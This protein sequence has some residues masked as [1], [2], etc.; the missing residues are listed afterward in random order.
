MKRTKRL[1]QGFTI[2]ELM[3]ALAVFSIILVIVLAAVMQISRMFYKGVTT[4][5]T[6]S[7]TRTLIDILAS[8]VQTS[9][10]EPLLYQKDNPQT[11]IN[12]S[13][14]STLSLTG[15]PQLFCIG[16]NRY[17]VQLN[18]QVSTRGGINQQ[19][20]AFLTDRVSSPISDECSPSKYSVA[21]LEDRLKGD[22]TVLMSDAKDLLGQNMRIV[23]LSV[24]KVPLG[25]TASS[26][27]SIGAKIVY[28]DQD[29][30]GLFDGS[31]LDP[32][33]VNSQIVCKG[34]EVG[35]EFCSVSKLETTVERRVR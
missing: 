12:D 26:I 29:L 14:S 19:K 6:Q 15:A 25:G 13:L 24:S 32:A 3:I 16:N 9:V 27:W 21:Q 2:V 7:T 31:T 28:G 34:S 33:V 23:E 10:E 4:S 18:K 5:Q 17:L 11:V 1:S 22:S 30:L 20:S 8:S 35:A